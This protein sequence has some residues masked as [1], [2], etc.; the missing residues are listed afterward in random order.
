MELRHLRYFMA[1]AE[2]GA[3]SRAAARPRITQ[4]AL[5][6]Q[7]HDLERSLASGSSSAPGARFV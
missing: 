6:R 1:V 2:A 4:P 5:W 7:V 3:F